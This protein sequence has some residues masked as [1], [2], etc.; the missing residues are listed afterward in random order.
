MKQ[1]ESPVITA[2][3]ILG[4]QKVQDTEYRCTRHMIRLEHE[5]GELWYHVTTKELL[6]LPP[7]EGPEAVREELIRK[8][9]LVP[10]DFDE[11]KQAMLLRQLTAS[12]APKKDYIN[13]FTVLTTTDC[14]ARCFYCYEKG[15]KRLDMSEQIARDTARYMLSVSKDKKITITWFGGEP[16]YNQRAIELISDALRAAGKEFS[17]NLVTNGYLLDEETARKAVECWNVQTAQITLDG[18][19]DIYNKRKAYIYHDDNAFERVLQN[20]ETALNAGI[21]IIVRLNVDRKNTEDIKALIELLGQR[22]AGR[23]HFTVYHKM[24]VSFVGEVNDF[25]DENSRTDC[26]YEIEE[27]LRKY[28]FFYEK[29]LKNEIYIHQCMA[30]NDSCAVLLPDG[31]IGECEHFSE[32]ELV[33]D[34]YNGIT[35]K[36]AVREWKETI[37]YPLCETCAMF[38]VCVI[39]KKCE[40]NQI[41]C[42]GSD[43]EIRLRDFRKK[44]LQLYEKRL[45]M[46]Q[47]GW[48]H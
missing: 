39:L 2:K 37:R 35:D 48:T 7:G 41:P 10:V 3:K 31:K 22:Y 33:G 32:S 6:L 21:R 42:E 13:S 26:Y 25:A 27:L 17:S 28:G 29:E 19:Q 45:I 8:W 16:L 23:C 11:N 38:P 20:I 43:H 1:I 46:Q 5:D 40:W 34:I 9:F 36:E 44:V 4:E 14:N 30:D 15:R 24:L 47:K 12:F 18:T